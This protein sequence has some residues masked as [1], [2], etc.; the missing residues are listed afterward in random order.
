MSWNL[1]SLLGTRI[2][3]LIAA[4][5]LGGTA[6]LL[7][8]T[9][10]AQSGFLVIAHPTVAVSS[11]TLEQASD[12]FLK[13]NPNWRDGTPIKPVNLADRAT[14]EAFDSTVHG[15]NSLAVRKYWQ[16]QVFT[17]RG[18]PPPQK[19][20]AEEVL[21]F[22]SSTPGAI[23]YVPAGTDLSRRQVRKIELVGAP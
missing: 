17:G 4:L 20:T 16:R 1:T 7:A 11:L 23:G 22:V 8:V 2:K 3:P 10:R 21:E 13:K 6:L 18:T 14:A 9:A 12:C 15:R 5:L 19:K